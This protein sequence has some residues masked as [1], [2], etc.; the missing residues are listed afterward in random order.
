MS[1]RGG[2]SSIC[3]RSIRPDRYSLNMDLVRT[4]ADAPAAGRRWKVRA[5]SRRWNPI[6][7]DARNGPHLRGEQRDDHV[8]DP[9]G[10]RAVLK[11]SSV[12]LATLAAP[13]ILRAAEPP[14]IKVGVLQPVTGALA[15]DGEFGRTGAEFA[16]GDVNAK[17]GIKSLAAPSWKWCSAM[18]APIRRRARR[19]SSVCSPRAWWRWWCL[20]Q[21][22]L[23]RRQPSGG[24][25]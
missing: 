12:A 10:R 17:G 25:L 11:G 13:A 9:L 7:Q 2:A 21:P 3:R 19:K 4:G 24:A 18:P 8:R 5:P 6:K 16:I 1:R 22:H 20:R 23:P 15:M 14:A